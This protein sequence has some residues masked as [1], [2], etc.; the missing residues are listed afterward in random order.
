MKSVE[1]NQEQQIVLNA[2]ERMTNAFHNKD[3][4]GVMK[5]YE[6]NAVIVFEPEQ[7]ESDKN[8]L[9]EKFKDAFMISPEFKY[10]GHEVFINGNVAMHIAPWVMNGQAPDGTKVEQSG[11]S[12]AILR[13]QKNGEWLMIFD[14][15]HGSFLMNKK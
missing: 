12:I 10:S 14:N 4:E 1:F 13:K 9:I 3:V 8:I 11:L 2:V 5:S 15:P 7:P 6:P